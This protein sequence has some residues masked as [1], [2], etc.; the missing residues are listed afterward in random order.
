MSKSNETKKIMCTR[1]YS[2][3]HLNFSHL[4]PDVAMPYNVHHGIA[5]GVDNP[6]IKLIV[7][8]FPALRR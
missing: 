7:K 4:Q 8:K 6:G 2:S 1:S 3:A 5:A